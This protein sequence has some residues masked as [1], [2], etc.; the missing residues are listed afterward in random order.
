MER[1]QI[2]TKFPIGSSLP[3]FS[4]TSTDGQTIG[5][6]YLRGAPVSL[7]FFSCNHCPYVKGSEDF[8]IGVVN[9]FKKD[10]IKAVSI[11]SN[12][13]VQY[14]DDSFEKMKQ[15]SK[16]MG[17]P[18]P[19]LFDSTQEVAKLF[20]AECTPECYVFN[21]QSKLVY[22]GPVN[23]SPRDATKVTKHYLAIAIAQTLQGMKA[24][25]AEINSIG[26]SIKWKIK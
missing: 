7:V 21:S 22:H 12:D 19:Y 1:T 8:L 2:S 4:L 16:D 9:E 6:D 11:S 23:D 18:Y 20:D 17:L 26:C 15:K 5:D 3:K 14:P 10:G 25:P 13:P 24:D